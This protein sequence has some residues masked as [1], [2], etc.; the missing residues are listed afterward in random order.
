MTSKWG[1]NIVSIQKHTIYRNITIITIGEIHTMDFQS[2]I[3]NN[4]KEII[5]NNSKHTKVLLEIDVNTIITP[6][7]IS[8]IGSNNIQ[9]IL[10]NIDRKYIEV[11]DVRDNYLGY[12]NKNWLYHTKHK[13][14]KTNDLEWYLKRYVELQNIISSPDIVV[15]NETYQ[16]IL[17]DF[18]KSI[19]WMYENIRDKIQQYRIKEDNDTKSIKSQIET[20]KD[21]NVSL[22]DI[23]NIRRLEEEIKKIKYRITNEKI[24]ILYDIRSLWGKIADFNIVKKILTGP[25]NTEYIILAGNHHTEN[26]NIMFRP[27]SKNSVVYK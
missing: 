17:Y 19:Q 10:K 9:D 24:S 11:F 5:K 15:Y 23:A 1:S 13:V 14:I 8:N 21:R 25:P 20:L 22:D 18:N 3:S 16:N 27:F 12:D 26:L 4:I 6:D 2:T 7:F